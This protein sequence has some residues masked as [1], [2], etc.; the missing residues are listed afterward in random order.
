MAYALTNEFVW[1]EIGQQVV[2]LQFE[3][4]A[5]WTLNETASF[6]WKSILEGCSAD[7]VAGRL[8]KTFDV[9]AES[10]REDVRELLK[11]W[12]E[13]KMLIPE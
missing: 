6:A 5:Y 1:K 12:V 2:V 8:T 11:N 4:G 3:S 9:S 10:A 7:E 13:K